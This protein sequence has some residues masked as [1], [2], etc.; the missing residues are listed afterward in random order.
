MAA[1]AIVPSR[2]AWIRSASTTTSP[3]AALM[4]KAVFFMRPNC[5]FPTAP[6]LA[7]PPGMCSVT[8]SAALK[9]SSTDATGVA[10]SAIC[11]GLRKGS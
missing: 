1:P 9:T 5:F 2:S 7:A 10:N 6:L 11:S 3:R 8:K 4:K